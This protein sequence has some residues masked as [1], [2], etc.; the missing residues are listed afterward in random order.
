MT[1]STREIL[2]K[3]LDP[4][5]VL[6]YKASKNIIRPQDTPRHVY[7]VA[8]GKVIQYDI[9]TNGTE[10]TMNVFG[11]GSVVSMNWLLTDL[12]NDFYYK[13]QEETV[14]VKVPAEDFY[15]FMKQNQDYVLELLTKV[16]RGS[17]GLMKRL[18]AHM[19]GDARKRILT[20]LVIDARRFAVI[21]A[22][23]A[24]I[25]ISVKELAARCGM[26]RETI[27][28][29][30]KVFGEMNLVKRTPD[31]IFIPSIKNIEQLL[32]S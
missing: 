2:V 20:E 14:L 21:N 1:D 5:P 30:F 3:F 29:Q 31:S 7:Y 17:D 27:S 16:I 32:Q 9:S 8:G 22:D 25:N 18:R 11:V 12:L 26:A 23:S 4:Y 28:R 24:N 15:N 13:T 6:E 10:M 19:Q